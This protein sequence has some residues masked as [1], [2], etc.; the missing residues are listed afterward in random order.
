MNDCADQA[1]RAAYSTL[2]ALITDLRSHMGAAQYTRFLELEE[3]WENMISEHCEWEAEFFAGGSIQPM[4]LSA[5]L[6]EQYRYRIESLRMNLCEGNG[7]TGECE[8]SLRY[9]Q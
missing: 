8:A 4:Q 5:C 6:N 3:D 1:A 9:K 2:Q 7:M